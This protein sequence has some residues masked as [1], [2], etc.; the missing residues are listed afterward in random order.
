MI[1]IIINI[2]LYFYNNYKEVEKNKKLTIYSN[3]LK[4][5]LLDYQN[6]IIALTTKENQISKKASNID[7]L[8][9]KVITLQNNYAKERENNMLLEIEL[10]NWR[11]KYPDELIKMDEGGK[12]NNVNVFK[13]EE[14]QFE[15]NKLNNKLQV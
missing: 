4:T 6:Q 1:F 2:Y 9:Q 8:K 12:I 5:S 14:M 7:T 3:E 13:I 11:K 15:I 10:N